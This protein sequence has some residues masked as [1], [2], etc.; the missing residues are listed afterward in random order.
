MPPLALSD[1]ELDQIF[2]A[3]QPLP[4][5]DRD[6]FLR[7]VAERLTGVTIGPGSVYKACHEAQRQFLAY[8]DLAN[9]G[10]WAKYR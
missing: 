2:R 8:P 6:A 10:S 4:V 9:G 7:A 3:A 5:A 1:T